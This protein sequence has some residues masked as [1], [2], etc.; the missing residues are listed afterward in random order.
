MF[1]YGPTTVKKVF[2][3]VLLYRTHFSLQVTIQSNNGLV[4]LW[5]RNEKI[6][7]LLFSDF[8]S[9]RVVAICRAF[10]IFHSHAYA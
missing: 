10:L 1:N 9:N 6:L 3:F 2:V 4:W 7:Y 8:H 5:R